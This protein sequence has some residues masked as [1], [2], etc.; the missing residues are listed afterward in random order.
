MERLTPP[1]HKALSF[2]REE[3]IAR[4]T[5]PT[6]RELCEHMA[7]G[8]VGS[9]QDVIAALRKKGFLE[10]PDRQSARSFVLTPKAQ[11]FLGDLVEGDDLEDD[12]WTLPCLGSVPA[13]NPLEAIEAR[14]GLLSFSSSLLPRPRPKR[15][16]LFALRAQGESM[17]GAGILSG[18]W[19]VV[20]GRSEASFGSIVVARVDQEITVKRF[21]EDRKKGPFLMPENPDFAPIYGHENPFVLVGKVV[22]LQRQF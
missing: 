19:L 5:P 3:M 21:M 14:V 4:G 13:G 6:L 15:E 11:F 18:D 7:F 17:I 12:V 20:Q 2:I 10:N 8:S 9:A 16:T 1:Q 22:A